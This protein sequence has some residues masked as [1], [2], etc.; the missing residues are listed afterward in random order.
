[1]NGRDPWFDWIDQEDPKQASWA[2]NYL[3]GKGQMLLSTNPPNMQLIELSRLWQHET[4][5]A[6]IRFITNLALKMKSAWSK[7]KSRERAG[8]KKPYSFEMDVQIG[9]ALK[10]LSRTSNQSISKTMEALIRDNEAFRKNLADLNKANI[11]KIKG[12]NNDI[13]R[14]AKRQK[15][16]ID[17]LTVILEQWMATADSLLTQGSRYYIALKGNGL[18]NKK[19]EIALSPEQEIVAEKLSKNW[20]VALVKDNKSKA[21]LKYFLLMSSSSNDA[22]AKATNSEGNSPPS[23]T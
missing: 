9:E 12:P 1:M 6:R 11:A 16:K 14:L 5:P 22:D 23:G 21:Q 20:K 8:G 4:D 13:D 18:M 10:R 3:V 17:S 7:Q 19:D 15:E 2:V